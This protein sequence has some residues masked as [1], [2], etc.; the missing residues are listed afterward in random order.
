MSLHYN[1]IP[2]YHSV[3]GFA[4]DNGQLHTQG[5]KKRYF[6]DI[7]HLID[8]YY[9]IYGIIP[10]ECNLKAYAQKQHV[11]LGYDSIEDAFDYVNWWYNQVANK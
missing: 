11:W 9:F 2:Y 3:W 6:S 1:T 7:A 4:H 5:Y 8:R 10:F